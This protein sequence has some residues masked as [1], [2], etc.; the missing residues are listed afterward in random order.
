MFISG[1][2][3]QNFGFA[4]LSF[5]LGYG[6]LDHDE[7]RSGD[8]TT[9]ADYSSDMITALVAAERDFALVNGAILTPRASF[10]YGEQDL[11]GYTET[12]SSAN[13]TVGDRTVTFSE[14]RIGGA[15]S[16]VVGGGSL[17]A[18]LA[19]VH[20]DADAPSVVD[21]AIFGNTLAL[22]SGGSGTD[23]FGEIGLSYEKAFDH[24]GNLRLEARSTLGADIS[25]QAA[26]ASY[27]WRF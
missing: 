4:D 25:T 14:T 24:G 10:M 13:A 17:S 19:A 20:R 3:A 27:E 1:I 23:T 5:G 7:T 12:G 26:W 8:A 11:D 9:D 15:Y 22:A 16:T 18:S 21:V 2:V 6:D